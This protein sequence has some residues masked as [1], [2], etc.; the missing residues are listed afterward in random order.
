M[1][2][3]KVENRVAVLV[4]LPEEVSA[5]VKEVKERTQTFYPNHETQA[6]HITL[7]SCKF[8]AAKFPELVQQIKN[9]SLKSFSIRLGE[10]VLTELNKGSKNLFA[11]VGL[12]DE[13]ALHA[14]HKQ[15]VLVAN[16]LRGNLIREKDIERFEKGIYSPELFSFIERYGYEHVGENFHPHI[17]LGEVDSKD[18]EKADLLRTSLGSLAGKEVLI[19]K[20]HILLSTR[21]VPSEKKVKESEVVEVDLEA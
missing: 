13:S 14:L 6:P 10:V 8:D 15:V 21:L 11:S 20:M 19:N 12:E 9:L 7:Y 1:E 4:Y 16:R 5:V 17:T 18:V 3:E 2:L